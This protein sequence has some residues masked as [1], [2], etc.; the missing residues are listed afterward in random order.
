VMG[1]L[2]AYPKMPVQLRAILDFCWKKWI[3]ALG[4]IQ[5]TVFW[6]LSLRQGF[7]KNVVT[8]V[9]SLASTLLFWGTVLSWAPAGFALWALFPAVICYLMA[10]EIV[11]LPH[12]LQLNQIKGEEHLPVWSQFQTSRTCL[13]P[14]WFAR[15]VVLNFNYHAEHHMYPDVPWYRLSE[16]HPVV[17]QSLGPALRTDPYFQW[18]LVNRQRSLS[19]VLYREPEQAHRLVS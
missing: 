15:L 1:F 8:R 14:R 18:N 12:H 16:L 7:K 17:R 9:L 10:N 6:I 4:L 19:D 5:N 13:Y 2:I 11:N 3:P